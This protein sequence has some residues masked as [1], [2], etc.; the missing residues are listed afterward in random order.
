ME[1]KRVC[2]IVQDLLPAYV[3]GLT[4]EETTS[5][6]DAH[7]TECEACRRVCREMSGVLPRE[8]VQAESLVRRLREKRDRQLA[9]R[10]AAAVVVL[11]VLAVC[12]LPLPR[13][14]SVTHEGMLWRCGD[15]EEAQLTPVTVTGTYWDYL[16]REDKFQGSIRVEA[17]PETHGNLSVTEM[18]GGQY[19]IWYETEE[20]R[21]NAFGT[22]FVR[23]DGS[24]MVIVDEDGHWDASA[25]KMLTAPASTREEA[26]ALA[27]AMADELSPN[28]LGPWQFE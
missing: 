15:P 6:V 17:C 24:V 22:M 3:D 12:L 20:S 21:L 8:A 18:G 10:W 13:S 5:F 11:L 26:V 27:N 25:G 23:K 19:G 14:I 4:K 1:S 7:L 28:W 9:L 16:F 2:A